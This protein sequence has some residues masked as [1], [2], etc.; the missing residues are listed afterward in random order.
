MRKLRARLGLVRDS[1][2]GISLIEAITALMIFSVIALGMTAALGTMTKLT[3]DDRGREVALGLAAQE[4]GEVQG[5]GDAF[6]VNDAEN[7]TQTVDGVVYTIDRTTQWVNTDGST[8]T[9]GGSGGNL[10]YKRVNVRVTW[11][12]MAILQGPVESDTLLAP[13]N[14]IN[15]PSFGTIIVDVFGAD[16]TGQAGVAVTAKSTSGTTLTGIAPTDADGCSYVLKVS[17]GT[18]NV[19]V[20]KS[21]F[22]DQNQVAA[23]SQNNLAVAAGSTKA[24]S[25]QYDKA[26]SF[27][28]QIAPGYQGT[29]KLPTSLKVNLL[30]TSPLYTISGTTTSS[31]LFPAQGGYS[32]VAG[33]N[34]FLS[35][36]TTPTC[37]SNDPVSWDAGTVAGVPLDVGQHQPA[38]LAPG[39]TGPLPVPLGI[40]SVTTDG[41]TS[42]LYA[43]TTAAPA[44]TGD[45]GCA[46][47]EN[48]TFTGL[49]SNTTYNLA[50]P[51]GSWI[52]SKTSSGSALSGTTPLTRGEVTGGVV[53][54]DPRG[55]AQ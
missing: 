54:L 28:T 14:R 49:A 51:F 45:P 33:D 5:V 23:P 43:R 13:A 48:Y 24:I 41:S 4:I 31:S 22:R 29:Y 15:D 12:N 11:P 18:Y 50:L 39:A 52:I 19:S 1:D 36:S 30:S 10:Q 25:F 20:S 44:G 17:P 26:A 2:V 53:T 7:Q 9:C 6:K 3:R 27:Q 32:A 40:V 8:A 55:P 47:A 21:G 37:L 16:G 42:T 35:N 46:S 34:Y 38:A